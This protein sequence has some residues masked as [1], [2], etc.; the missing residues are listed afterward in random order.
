LKYMRVRFLRD[1]ERF[2]GADGETYGPFKKGQVAVLPVPNANMLLK[3][4]YV[5]KPTKKEEPSLKQIFKGETLAG[6]VE[7]ARVK[8]LTEFA[9]D[10]KAEE[11]REKLMRELEEIKRELKELKEE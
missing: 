9:E 3:W 8:P 11:I 2:R 4:G 5:E 7:A 1:Y 6:Y 10:E